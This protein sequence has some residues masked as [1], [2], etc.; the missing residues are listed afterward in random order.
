MDPSYRFGI[1]EEFFLADAATRGTP[2]RG[3]KP[4]H[5][6]VQA[7][8]PGAERELLQAQV[9]TA[10]PPTVSFSEARSA[11]GGF[12]A[13]IAALAREHGLVL[14]ACGT[15]PI[16]R[17][18]R[19]RRTDKDRYEKLMNEMQLLARRNV[20]CGMHVHVEVPGRRIG[21]TS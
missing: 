15:Q 18:S 10:S 7:Q 1:E 17:W 12:R 8:I 21:S 3:L 5:D 4:F 19:Q 20:V 2:R 16:A 14:L 13:G 11:L 6:A 9:E